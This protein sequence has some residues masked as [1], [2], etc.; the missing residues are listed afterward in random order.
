MWKVRVHWHHSCLFF[1]ISLK[2]KKLWAF[3]ICE[4]G[5]FHGNLSVHIVHETCCDDWP[6]TSTFSYSNAHNS[7][8]FNAV[9]IKLGSPLDVL[10]A[11]FIS[12]IRLCVRLIG[13]YKYSKFLKSFAWLWDADMCL[14]ILDDIIKL[15]KKEGRGNRGGRGAGGRR[16]RGNMPMIDFIIPQ[17]Y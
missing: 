14:L 8:I 12:V 9:V 5:H 10:S 3:Q 6:E 16:G 15:N 4:Y 11:E 2:M 13:C 17:T 1:M 7:F